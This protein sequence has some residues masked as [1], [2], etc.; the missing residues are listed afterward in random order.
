MSGDEIERQLRDALAAR[1]EGAV[2]DLRPVPP[3]RFLTA[4][5][6]AR[7]SHQWLAPAAAAAAVLGLVG[8]VLAI[9][10]SGGSSQGPKVVGGHSA[11][12]SSTPGTSATV[13]APSSTSAASDGAGKSVHVKLFNA[14]NHTVGVAMPVI[15]IFSRKITNARPF[16][17]ATRV[18]VNEKPVQA[19]WYFEHSAAG[20]GAMEAHLRPKSYWPAHAKVHVSLDTRGKAAGHGLTYDDSLTLDFTTGAHTV[21]TVDDSTNTL[22][23]RTDGVSV[24]TFPVS[25]GAP[26]TPTFGGTKVIMSKQQQV[27]LKGPGYDEVVPYALR[28]TYS[29]EYLVG[30]PSAYASIQKRLDVSNGCTDL[31]KADAERLYGMLGVGDPVEYVN[32]KGP[33]MSFTDGFGDWNVPWP[34]WL[35]GGLLP[36]S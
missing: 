9:A 3:A 6:P 10:G 18:T 19:A 12:G 25:L 22:M 11:A 2:D 23:V 24:A 5:A 1:A 30:V 34:L 26:K 29:G 13:D 7:R 36:T 33:S 8:G 14:D 32:G 17:Q 31:V 27:R 20:L 4:P 21:A 28:L 15:A 35:K 16:V